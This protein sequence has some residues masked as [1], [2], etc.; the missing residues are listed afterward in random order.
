M[1]LAARYATARS[2]HSEAQQRRTASRTA[3]SPDT[4]AERVLLPREAGERQVLGGRGGPDRHL[5]VS[6]KP[7]V[8]LRDRL[9]DRAR[10][11]R[12]EQRL[13]A[14]STGTPSA[15][16][17]YAAVVTQNPSG[18]GNPARNS[19]PRFAALPPAT[20]TAPRSSSRSGMI[21]ASAIPQ[22]YARPPGEGGQR[23][24][25]SRISI[26]VPGTAVASAAMSSGS[27]VSTTAESAPARTATT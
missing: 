16:S 26:R 12:R 1:S 8:R 15:A 13:P 11:G 27:L 7:A 18:T 2:V 14:S 21:S 9:G 22:A 23:V 5:H 3:P 25:G 20:S 24:A 6:A 17:A 19:S 10:D 4:F